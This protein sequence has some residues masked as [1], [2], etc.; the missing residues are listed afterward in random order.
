MTINIKTS[1]LLAQSEVPVTIKQEFFGKPFP[2]N[3]LG[4][5]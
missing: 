3:F 5:V 4:K 1:D 2:D